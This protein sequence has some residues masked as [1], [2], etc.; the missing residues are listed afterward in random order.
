MSPITGTDVTNLW[1]EI[2]RVR[3]ARGDLRGA[4][5]AKQSAYIHRI[6]RAVAGRPVQ[7]YPETDATY[8][9]RIAKW[10]ARIAKLSPPKLWEIR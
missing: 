7:N 5:T 6:S 2:A 3:K 4:N 10:E 1:T 8:A 9:A